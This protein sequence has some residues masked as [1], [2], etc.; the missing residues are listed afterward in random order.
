[1]LTLVFAVVTAVGIATLTSVR[2][3]RPD[4]KAN[5]LTEVCVLLAACGA[6]YGP[7]G[8]GFV[9][10]YRFGPDL[11]NLNP[12][13]GGALMGGLLAILIAGGM[14][15]A[16][17]LTLWALRRPLELPSRRMGVRWF[18]LLM[19]AFAL[20]FGLAMPFFEAVEDRSTGLLW[21]GMGLFYTLFFVATSFV[22]PWLTFLRSPRLAE[23]PE[24]G[25]LQ[26]WVDEVMTGR[27]KR[28]IAVRLHEGG[29]V[30]AFVLWG[31]RRPWLLVGEG[32]LEEMSRSEVRGVLAHE[33]AHLLR[34]DHVRLLLSGMVWALGMTACT[35]L[36]IAPLYEA[37]RHVLGV[38]ATATA[39]TLYFVA[40]GV[41]MRRV[42]YATDRLAVELLDGEGAPLASALEKMATLKKM[43][44]K[45]K[46]A[47]HPAVQDRIEAIARASNDWFG[48]D[49]GTIE[50]TGDII[51]PVDVEWEAEV[52]PDR[53]LNP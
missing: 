33:I 9:L 36:V 14:G 27:G 47:M 6:V 1:M 52:N 41:M 42:E 38:M 29:L 12:F 3:L 13:I 37:D 45:Q 49:Q 50:I 46:T 51:S 24:S 34:R 21:V 15:L 17:V 8:V 32:L 53:V 30:N 23:S 48:A 26:A 25:D 4:R 20:L 11:A 39:N 35:M 10:Q 18:L 44:L 7:V 19:A 28:P 16:T 40:L 43:P 22:V 2:T 5:G 31:I